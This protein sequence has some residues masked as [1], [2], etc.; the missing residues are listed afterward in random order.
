MP[1]RSLPLFI[2]VVK[3]SEYWAMMYCQALGNLHPKQK[4]KKK[5]A[6]PV[7]IELTTLLGQQ[8]TPL[9]GRLRSVLLTTPREGIC[10]STQTILKPIPSH[11]CLMGRPSYSET[12]A[13]LFVNKQFYQLPFHNT[14]SRGSL[15]L[16]ARNL[17]GQYGWARATRRQQHLNQRSDKIVDSGW[18]ERGWARD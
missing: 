11:P 3:R 14:M 1:L 8:L 18:L 17:I 9:G 2:N 5:R 6:P 16:L 12:A 13:T 7:R 4:V 15:I 10:N